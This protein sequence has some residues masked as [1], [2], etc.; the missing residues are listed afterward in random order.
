M[1]ADLAAMADAVR[2]GLASGAFSLP[3]TPRRVIDPG[4]DLQQLQ[5][6]RVDVVG[7]K[8]RLARLDRQGRRQVDSLIDVAVRR[9]LTRTDDPAEHDALLSLVQ[10]IGDWFFTHP[11]PGRTESLVEV[12]TDA[13]GTVAWSVPDLSEQRAFVAVVTL[14]FRGFR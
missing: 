5:S 10:E 14:T 3:F 7:R 4:V 9:K 1:T 12:D 8:E 2:A 13:T 6:L 11:L